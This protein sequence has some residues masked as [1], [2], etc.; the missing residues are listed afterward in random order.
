MWEVQ[1][2]TAIELEPG[3]G[4][5][6]FSTSFHNFGATVRVW[7]ISVSEDR[8]TKVGLWTG[9]LWEYTVGGTISDRD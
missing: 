5:R 1:L 2:L 4:I 3:D 6:L 7:G 8:V 9:S